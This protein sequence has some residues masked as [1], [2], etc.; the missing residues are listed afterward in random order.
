LVTFVCVLVIVFEKLSV[1]DFEAYP[2]G[3]FLQRFCFSV[4][5]VDTPWILKQ[6]S[7][8]KAVW[9]LEAIQTQI[10][11]YARADL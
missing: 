3:I 11:I 10:Q 5:L 9:I 8:F 7:E 4:G 2:E 1:D 6:N